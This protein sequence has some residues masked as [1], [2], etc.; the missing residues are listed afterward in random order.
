MWLT[1]KQNLVAYLSEEDAL[2]RKRWRGSISYRNSYLWMS[3][4]NTKRSAWPARKHKTIKGLICWQ[5][6]PLAIQVSPHNLPTR[7]LANTVPMM[8]CVINRVKLPGIKFHLP[9][10]EKPKFRQYRTPQAQIPPRFGQGRSSTGDRVG[11][12]PLPAN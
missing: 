8:V 12:L 9:S 10:H 7:V 1:I 11:R 6:H 5:T 2:T 3:F 4:K